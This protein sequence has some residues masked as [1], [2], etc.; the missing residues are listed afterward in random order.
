MT[1]RRDVFSVKVRCADNGV[2]KPVHER[3]FR[4]LESARRYSRGRLP[5][6]GYSIDKTI[7]HPADWIVNGYLAAG[8]TIED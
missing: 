4:S 5:S 2:N 8:N 6:S 1:I 7:V 3:M